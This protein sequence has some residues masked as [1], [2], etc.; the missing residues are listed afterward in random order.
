MV[1]L[2]RTDPDTGRRKDQLA[3]LRA[4]DVHR[5]LRPEDIKRPDAFRGGVVPA[6]PGAADAASD[7]YRGAE[8]CEFPGGVLGQPRSEWK[9]APGRVWPW[10][11]AICSASMTSEVRMWS[12]SC[13]PTT[14]RVHKSMT[15][16][17]GGLRIRLGGLAGDH[18]AGGRGR[19]P[20]TV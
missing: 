5:V 16:A 17:A 19:D 15:V 13:Q 12:A 11:M 9:I 18:D 8:L 3:W 20:G 2:Y 14:M 4:E 10:V 7:V 6:H 1:G